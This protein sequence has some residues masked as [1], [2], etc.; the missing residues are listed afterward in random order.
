MVTLSLI[1]TSASLTAES[2]KC[3]KKNSKCRFEILPVV[4]Q[5]KGVAGSVVRFPL[6][7][8]VLQ[9]YDVSRLCEQLRIKTPTTSCR[10]WSIRAWIWDLGCGRNSRLHSFCSRGKAAIDSE[11]WIHIICH[12]CY[13]INVHVSYA[14]PRPVIVQSSG[15][16]PPVGLTSTVAFPPH[17]SS[18]SSDVS[19]VLSS[20]RLKVCFQRASSILLFLIQER[21]PSICFNAVVHSEV[22]FSFFLLLQ[23]T[24]VVI[25]C[26]S[27]TP[28]F[29]A[30]APGCI[31]LCNMEKTP[32]YGHPWLM[33]REQ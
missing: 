32:S 4:A 18:P 5:Q 13:M 24:R 28:L 19:R 9:R 30:A 11:V 7:P 6:G 15:S 26:C 31:I 33:W 25:F 1:V 8:H 14:F 3:K 2:A 23:A 12:A 10:M 27:N 22:S 16:S 20:G 29:S 21:L 17:K